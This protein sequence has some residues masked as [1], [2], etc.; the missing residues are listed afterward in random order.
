MR[1]KDIFEGWIKSEVLTGRKSKLGQPNGYAFLCFRI[2][3][4][5]EEERASRRVYRGCLRS[6]TC[7]GC[8][9]CVCFGCEICRFSDCSCQTCIDFTRNAVA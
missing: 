7:R 6:P 5:D 2:T 3:C 1:Y 4:E 8:T 9:S